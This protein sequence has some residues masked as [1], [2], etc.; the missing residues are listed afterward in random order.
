M[1]LEYYVIEN[2]Y[3]I[4]KKRKVYVCI[5]S[6]QILWHDKQCYLHILWDFS[7]V[8]NNLKFKGALKILLL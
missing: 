1:Q 6:K 5:V 3:D 8:T 4:N 7:E 2:L